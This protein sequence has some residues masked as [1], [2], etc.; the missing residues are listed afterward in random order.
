MVAPWHLNKTSGSDTALRMMDSRAFRTATRAV[1]LMVAD[2]E[3]PGEGIVALDKANAGTLDVPAIRYR[4]RSADYTVTETDE[5]TCE[6]RN[7]AASC[8]VAEWVGV[9]CG[10]GRQLARDLLTPAMVRDDDAKA[11]LRDYLQDA[12][13]TVRKTVVAAGSAAGFGVKQLQRA[14]QTLGV[15]YRDEVQKRPG[16]TPLK[17]SVW[18]L[19]DGGED[20]RSPCTPPTVPPS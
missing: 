8:G 20:S 13:E 2:P 18:R 17:H 4:L 9:E 3:K 16:S 15:V 7:L 12:G 19:P 6:I 1:L 14:A 5:Q 11:W 10:H